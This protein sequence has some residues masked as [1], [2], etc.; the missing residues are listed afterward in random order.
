MK[1]L[2]AQ[3]E[4]AQIVQQA[5]VSYIS[6]R[7]VIS[8]GTEIQVT[9]TDEGATIDLITGGESKTQAQT[10]AKKAP[11][12][13][14]VESNV[15][16]FQGPRAMTHGECALSAAGVGVNPA[17]FAK[18]T[19]TVAEDETVPFLADIED[20]TAETATEPKAAVVEE[21]A[22]EPAAPPGRSL[23]ANL[24]KPTNETLVR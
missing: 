22:A 3:A 11:K 16:S 12:P 20:V 13:A 17:V 18:L 4:I 15:K 6:E 21:E 8:D 5:L 9:M 2:L 1:I 10:P 19:E 23:C 24:R 14:R 7:L